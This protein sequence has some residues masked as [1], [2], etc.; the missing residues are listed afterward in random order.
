MTKRVIIVSGGN[1]GL[2]SGIVESL[3]A[4]TECVV[5]TFGRKET[6]FISNLKQQHLDDFRFHFEPIDLT[7]TKSIHDFV[8]RVY[9]KF[10]SIDVL[11]NNAG[12]A[13]D[14][15]LALFR[16]DD[17]GRLLDINVQGTVCLTKYCVRV[18]M[19]QPRGKIINIT[20]IVGSTGYAGLSVYSATKAALEGFTRSLARELGPR[21]ITV[22]AVAPGYLKTEMTHGLSESQ[23]NQI[24]RRTPLGRLGEVNDLIPLVHFLC[25]DGSN[26]ITGHTFV[27]DGGLT[28]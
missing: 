23:L 14:G 25:S 7:E 1:Q 9:K 28:A 22:N 18:M 21:F 4:K 12:I 10:G 6:T 5:A 15:V 3:L 26:F 2:G 16:E 24:V 13:L 20:S 11:I 17:I 8:Q 27:V 19:T